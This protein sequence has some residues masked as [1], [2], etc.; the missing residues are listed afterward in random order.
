MY[1]FTGMVYMF[2]LF[3]NLPIFDII[4]LKN[5]YQTVNVKAYLAVF[6]WVTPV[7][8]AILKAEVEDHKILGQPH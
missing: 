8:P 7:I 3:Q 5:F 1:T 4:K 2:H 6:R